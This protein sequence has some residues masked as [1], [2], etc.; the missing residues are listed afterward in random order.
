MV[1]TLVHLKLPIKLAI[2]TSLVIICIQS[3][4][5]FLGYANHTDFLLP[6]LTTVV[7]ANMTGS[8]LGTQLNRHLSGQQLKI[9]FAFLI[10]AVGLLTLLGNL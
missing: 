6:T 2:G 10:R 7:S 8:L 1:P 5:G 9:A 3:A 4:I